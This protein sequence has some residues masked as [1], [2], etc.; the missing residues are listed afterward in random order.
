MIQAEA[1]KPRVGRSARISFLFMAGTLVLA[2]W[3]HLG[4]LLLAILFAYLAL[5]KLHF[6]KR[7]G[8]W[9][10]VGLF[11]ILVSAIAY[12][13]GHFINSAVKALPRIAEDSV[14]SI[15]KWASG[16]QI[17]LPFSDYDSL[18]DFALGTVSSEVQYL[19]RFANFARGATAQFVFLIAGCAV[20]ISL[21]LSPRLLLDP[22]GKTTAPNLYTV[23]C[24]AIVE[25]F[26]TFYQSFA[27]VIAAQIII[28]AINTILTAI[29]VLAVK[30][31]Y[32]LV[33]IGTT[34]LCGLLPVI[35]NLISNTIIIGVAFTLS[36]RTALEAL[37]FLVVVHKLEYLLNSKIIG[38]RI[39]NPLWLTLLALLLG[40]R[41]MGI[42]GMILAPVVLNYLRIEAS[43]IKA[44]DEGEGGWRET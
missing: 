37:V 40:E 19:G 1:I 5:N 24:E 41:L 30:L 23:C 44:G 9:V 13:L 3:L 32:A 14:P 22:A 4:G 15:I 17:E 16:H 21:F 27:T 26:R 6:A 31:P 2:G 38:Q 20:A 33:L 35:G 18:K 8:K 11:L 7:G 42:P 43:R 36:P 25:R 10:A 39:R 29:F 34:F 12:A 28:S